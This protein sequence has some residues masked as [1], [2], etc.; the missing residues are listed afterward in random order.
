MSH[1][2]NNALSEIVSF[3]KKNYVKIK[4]NEN[5]KWEAIS[6]FQSHWDVNAADFAAMLKNALKKTTNLMDTGYYYPRRMIQFFTEA[7]P[8]YTRQM[9]INLYNENLDYRIRIKN[10]QAASDY[11]LETNFKD[12]GKH[13]QDSRA[14]MVYLNLKYPKIYYF[15][16]YTMFKNFV[17]IVDYDYLPKEGDEY[18]I[19]RFLLLC[20]EILSKIKSDAELLSLDSERHTAYSNV[21]PEYHLL[22]QD[23]IYTGTTYY[24]DHDLLK[25]ADELIIPTEFKLQLKQKRPV[26]KPNPHYNPVLEAKRNK[27]IGEAG[28]KFIYDQERMK[29]KSHKKTEN[30]QVCW[31]SQI[32]GDGAGY[33]IKS[34]DKDGTEIYIEVKTTTGPENTP[35]YITANELAKSQECPEQFYLYRVYDFDPITGKGKYSIKHG[36]ISDL[37]ISAESFK[38]SF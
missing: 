14:V 33:D 3:Y 6:H 32:E 19:P 1:L 10:F 22:V 13:Y 37:C 17:K 7:D 24:Q 36:D 15:Y 4:N 16:K 12:K 18:N 38:V 8:D 29:L 9:F 2:N 5:Y 21:D 34:Y 23:V 26:L 11:M 27:A 30:K 31:I 20:E 28:E 25:E 35:F